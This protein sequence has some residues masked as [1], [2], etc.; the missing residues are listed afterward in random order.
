MKSDVSGVGPRFDSA[1]IDR[2]GVNV[3]RYPGGAKKASAGEALR[4]E[5][6]RRRAAPKPGH[7]EAMNFNW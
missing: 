1:F 4:S 6:K 2:G 7:D 5:N 3:E